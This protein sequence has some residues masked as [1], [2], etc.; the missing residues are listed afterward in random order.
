VTGLAILLLVAI[1]AAATH[2]CPPVILAISGSKQFAKAYAPASLA[3]RKTSAN[4]AQAY[5]Q[6]CAA[7]MLNSRPLIPVNGA[8]AG[9]LFLVNAPSAN[10]AS[11]YPGEGRMVL[12]YPFIE[13]DGKVSV[14]DAAE[15]KEAIFC[16]V[17]G[18]SDKEQEESG[19][20]LPD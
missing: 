9:K 18:A 15:L 19:R 12:E 11:I 2:H 7:G 6:A 13:S 10:V 3:M 8:N 14:P 16:A 4:F 1:P 5:K 17:V 20:C